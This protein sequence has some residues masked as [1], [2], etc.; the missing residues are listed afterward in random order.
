M[1]TREVG[2][3]LKLKPKHTQ[4]PR[5]PIL[6]NYRHVSEKNALLNYLHRRFVI[7]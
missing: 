1:Y 7:Y 3:H 2:K 4:V 5:P 6:I